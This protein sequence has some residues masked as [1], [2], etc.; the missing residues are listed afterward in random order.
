MELCGRRPGCELHR[1]RRAEC[2]CQLSTITLI[3]I[4]HRCRGPTAQNQALVTNANDTNGVNNIDTDT[5]P[6]ITLTGGCEG[7]LISLV[8]ATLGPLVVGQPGTLNVTVDERGSV[9]DE[10]RHRLS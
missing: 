4:T 1:E 2:D 8:D 5:V 9:A 6:V 7:R 10:P 3:V